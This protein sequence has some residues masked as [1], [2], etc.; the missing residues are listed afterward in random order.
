[1]S[2]GDSARGVGGSYGGTKCG[3]EKTDDIRSDAGVPSI[4]LQSHQKTLEC[5]ERD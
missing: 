4:H 5:T 3:I 1:M 2:N